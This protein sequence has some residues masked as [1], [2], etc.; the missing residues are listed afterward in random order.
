[1]GMV[2][3]RIISTGHDLIAYLDSKFAGLREKGFTV[4]GIVI[5]SAMRKELTKECQRVMGQPMKEE[6][7][8][9]RFRGALLI[10]DGNDLKRVEVISARAPVL[11]VGTDAFIGGLKRVPGGRRK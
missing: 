9:N 3:G 11:P 4:T 1:M 7:T 5:G 6:E 2:E 10:E 8:V